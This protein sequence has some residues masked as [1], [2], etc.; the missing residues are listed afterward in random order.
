MRTSSFRS[1]L[2]KSIK[3]TQNDNAR[4]ADKAMRTLASRLSIPPESVLGRLTSLQEELTRLQGLSSAAEARQRRMS[5]LHEEARVEL[6]QVQFR[7]QEEELTDEQVSQVCMRLSHALYLSLTTTSFH[8]SPHTLTHT[9][10]HTLSS[11]LAQRELLAEKAL[12]DVNIKLENAMG[13]YE[14]MNKL[15]RGTC[16]EEEGSLSLSVCL[17]LQCDSLTATAVCVC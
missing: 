12:R 4:E 8:L 6:S 11:C 3:E 2:I 13:A 7:D 15:L 5:K 14:K 9:H 17:A 1:Q 16:S 10:T